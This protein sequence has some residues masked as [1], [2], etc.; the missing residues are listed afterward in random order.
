MTDETS[1]S[2]LFPDIVIL[3]GGSDALLYATHKRAEQALQK[4]RDELEIRVKERTEELSQAN[5]LL[6]QEIAIRAQ[7]EENLMTLHEQLKEANKNLE[8]A[9]THMREAKASIV[10]DIQN[11]RLGVFEQI[12]IHF[13]KDRSSSGQLQVRFFPVNSKTGKRLLALMRHP[14][15]EVPQ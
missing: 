11:T 5:A 12:L 14:E 4:V 9:Y 15:K 7:A 1:F 2:I 6:K 13:K 8:L 10:Q 3:T